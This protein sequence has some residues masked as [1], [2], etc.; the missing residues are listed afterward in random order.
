MQTVSDRTL[1]AANSILLMRVK[2]FNDNFVQI[3]GYA[4]DN[5]FDFGQGKIGETLMG[6]DGQQSGGFTPY[7]VDFNI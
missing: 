1:T 5:A 3:E 2:G 4:A 6:V 7:E